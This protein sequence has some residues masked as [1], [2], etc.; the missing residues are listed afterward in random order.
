MEEENFKQ[1]ILPRAKAISSTSGSSFLDVCFVLF[2]MQQLIR[3]PSFPQTTYF[4]LLPFFLSS[5]LP[6]FIS[7]FLPFV[8][9]A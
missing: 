8:L 1:K 9:L 2:F 3:F 6:F 7:S 5:F 4:R